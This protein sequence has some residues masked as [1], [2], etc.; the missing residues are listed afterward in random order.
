VRR[1]SFVLLIVFIFHTISFSQ[2]DTLIIN[3]STDKVKIGSR[4]YYVHIVA[5]GETLY[6][7]SKAYN[8]SQKEIAKENPEIFLGLQVGQALKIPVVDQKPTLADELKD[9]FIYHKVKKGQTLYSLSKKYDVSVDDIIAFN[10]DSRYGINIGEVLKIPVNPQVVET[11]QQYPRK[12]EPMKDT[13]RVEDD[14]FIY[15][16]V[17]KKETI[18]SLAREFDISQ[19]ELFKHNPFLADGLKAG[20]TIKIPKKQILTSYSLLFDSGDETEDTSGLFKKRTAIAYSDSIQ[21]LPCD[22]MKQITEPFKVVV[23]LPFYLDKN[24]EEYSIDSTEVDEFGKKIYEKVFYDSYYIYPRSLNFVEFYEGFL[25]A[26][27][28]LKQLGLNLDLYVYDTA[29]DTSRIKEILHYPMMES[30]DLIIGPIYNHELK[31]V[32]EFSKRHQIKMVSPLWDN[33]QLVDENPYFFQIT[34]SYA[35][36]MDKYV[37]YISQ[38]KDKNLILVHDGDSLRYDNIQLV[39]DK[40]F[41]RF[42]DSVLANIQFKEVIF[43][44]SINVLEH[45]A[46]KETE[47]IFIVPSNDEAFVT[48]VVTKLN[49]LS[50]FNYSVKVCGLSRWQRFENIDTE[51]YFNLNLCLSTPYFVDYKKDH[52]KK[53]ILKYRETFR[54]EPQ[55]YAIHGYDIGMYFLSALLYYG[56]NFEH[57][58]YHHSKDLLQANYNFVRWYQNSGFENTDVS[59]IEYKENYNISKIPNQNN[60]KLLLEAK[61]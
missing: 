46:S 53:F 54:T 61:Y 44:D 18:F 34:P 20:Q 52:V 39:K 59:L 17:A 47:N 33:L 2:T 50:A 15:H 16:T 57:C 4:L 21:P 11:I 5:R 51:Y 10:P 56:E 30:M 29:N 27:D 1:L 12:D 38:F 60:P 42:S 58:I 37:E 9:E 8:V 19:D 32:S 36:Q 13:V 41:A 31:L 45:A 26:V 22:T 7:L 6:S 55:Q 28:S 23:L 14:N 25:L 35:A 24:D 49:T 48:N 3:K 40:L 43:K